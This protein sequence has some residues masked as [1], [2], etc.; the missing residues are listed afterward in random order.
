M[1]DLERLLES[2]DRALSDISIAFK[3]RIGFQDHA[4][5]AGQM[6]LEG[7]GRDI[8]DMVKRYRDLGVDEMVLDVAPESLQTTL[9]TME[10]FVE[11]VR[12]KL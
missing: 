4:P 3:S 6:P 10:R 11:E 1:A 2:N 9:D 7:R 12:C 5:A 8:L